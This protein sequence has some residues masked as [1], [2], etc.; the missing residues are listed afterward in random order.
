MAIKHLLNHKRCSNFRKIFVNLHNISFTFAGELI[1]NMTKNIKLIAILISLLAV[2]M[3]SCS[4]NE[5]ES[6]PTERTI[7][8]YMAAN[9]SLGNMNSD[10]KDLE[11]M[12]AAVT[13][14]ALGNNNRLMIFYAPTGGSQTL[15]EMLPTGNLNKVVEYSGTE[16]AVSA[17]FML[18]VFNDTKSYAPAFSYGLIMWSHAMGW[19]ENGLEDDGPNSANTESDGLSPKTWGDDRGRTMNI[20]TLGRVL[21]ASPWDWVYFDCC[22]MGSVEVAYELRYAVPMM[23]ASAS[24]IPLD[25]MPYEKNLP[26]LF[27]PEPDLIGAAQNTFDY[28]NNRTG[29]DQTCTISVLD[30]TRMDA[31]ANATKNIYSQVS[32]VVPTKFSNLPLDIYSTHL[33]YDFG[34]WV[35][36][37]V[38]QAEINNPVN[39]SLLNTGLSDWEKAYSDVV[40]YKAATPMLWSMVDLSR[41]SGISTYIPRTESQLN[42]RGY[43]TLQWYDKVARY[44]F[45]QSTY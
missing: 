9:N 22:F 45:E 4:D 28:Y 18:K 8:V 7:L 42:Y 11:E 14:G 12:K 23:V 29:Q 2:F 24:E 27:E 43:N 25:G 19:T 37:L 13:N 30:L 41:F 32:Y 39:S 17:D 3:T 16:F 5:P 10:T 1:I 26:L 33:F 31:L 6:L 44:L 40:L 38:Q 15:Y 35:K 21:E 36:G 34:V 20:S